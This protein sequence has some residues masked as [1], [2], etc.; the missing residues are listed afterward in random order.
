M[1]SMMAN[2]FSNG[3]MPY[4]R[5]G[6]LPQTSRGNMMNGNFGRGGMMAG[7]AGMGK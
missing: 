3:G 7:M 6:M 5:R 2:Q 1:M 4:G